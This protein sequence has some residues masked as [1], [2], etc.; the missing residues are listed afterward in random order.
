MSPEPW[1]PAVQALLDWTSDRPSDAVARTPRVRRLFAELLPSSLPFPLIKVTGTNGKGSTCAILESC[2][3]AAGQ[4][5]GLFTS[6]HM[7]RVQE[8]IRV[9]GQDVSAAELDVHAAHVLE[10]FQDFV[11]RHGQ[12]WVPAFFEGL[13]LM[14]LGIFRER[15]VTVAVIEGGVGGA[16]DATARLPGVVSALTSVGLDHTRELGDT[17]E[18]IATD[19]AGIADPGS[20]LVIGPRIT[21]S[22]RAV[23]ETV[24][25]ARHVTLLDTRPDGLTVLDQGWHGSTVRLTWR[26]QPRVVSLNLLGTHQRDNLQVAVRVLERLDE[27]GMIRDDTALA[28][29]GRVRW[30]GR[31]ESLGTAPR[32]LVDVAHNAH[33]FEALAATLDDLVPRE[34]RVLLYGAAGDKD[35]AA[36]LALLPRLAPE[37]C[38][39]EGFHRAAP[40]ATLRPR[41]PAGLRCLDTFADPE[42]AVTALT[43]DLHDR[44]ILV[45][46]SVFLAGVAREAILSSLRNTGQ[47]R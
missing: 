21:G 45:A 1:P 18:A 27:I 4:T 5:T 17:L 2:L 10:Q 9:Q 42:Q 37:V 23:V 41:L 33:G 19:K 34:R 22:V 36:C 28:G 43:R 6:P 24:C 40:T 8:R 14:A 7:L 39:V 16:S 11:A 44:T 32:W 46:G 3:Q 15:G 47:S 13:I 31:L 38:L 35:Y 12:A 25:A 20:T 26:G 29:A 30:A